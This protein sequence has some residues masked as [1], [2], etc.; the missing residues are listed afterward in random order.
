MHELGS[1]LLGP[2]R[3]G[4]AD[5][6]DSTEEAVLK[7]E[8]QAYR[9]E[10]RMAL[11][12]FRCF[13]RCTWR[14]SLCALGLWLLSLVQFL[15]ITLVIVLLA[16]YTWPL[17]PTGTLSSR[18]E[19]E[20]MCQ[21]LN[22]LTSSYYCNASS[23]VYNDTEVIPGGYITGCREGY[24]C[25]TQFHDYPCDLGTTG[26][27]VILQTNATKN[28]LHYTIVFRGTAENEQWRNDDDFKFAHWR[29]IVRGRKGDVSEG[30]WAEYRFVGPGVLSRL[31]QEVGRHR[32]RLF[33]DAD[34]SVDRGLREFGTRNLTLVVLGHS[35]GCPIAT[36]FTLDARNQGF[37]VERLFV[38]SPPRLGDNAMTSYL[39]EA[40]GD[41]AI[42]MMDAIDFVPSAPPRI[43]GY[44]MP[45][46]PSAMTTYDDDCM[47]CLR[48]LFVASP[49]CKK[50]CGDSARI[51]RWYDP[52]DIRTF[53][54]N[55][56]PT[57]SRLAQS[58]FDH[59]GQWRRHRSSSFAELICPTVDMYTRP[60]P[61]NSNQKMYTRNEGDW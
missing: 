36:L 39:E 32:A 8:R 7:F 25:R 53:Y 24:P 29:G 15:I 44:Q 54:N 50:R 47:T 48:Q 4:R 17:T 18:Q 41:V 38:V 58:K 60:W 13:R 30:F 34:A 19:N 61:P 49:T 16:G 21:H 31:N 12:C 6:S 45:R 55:L 9:C 1:H 2:E 27:A 51:T 3:R 11:C 59:D 57:L 33:P 46:F 35:L 10:H 20:T 52:S 5:S 40:L 14:R 42:Q 26:R 37:N 56:G 43:S 23:V 28:P 22:W